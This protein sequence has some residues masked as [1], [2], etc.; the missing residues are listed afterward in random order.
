MEG[1]G[2]L[3]SQVEK[4]PEAPLPQ[5]GIQKGLKVMLVSIDLDKWLEITQNPKVGDTL[6]PVNVQCDFLFNETLCY[7]MLEAAKTAIMKWNLMNQVVKDPQGKPHKL[8]D[9]VRGRR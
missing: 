2:D 1:N 3:K 9:F 4:N 5:K 7:G 8:M 6:P